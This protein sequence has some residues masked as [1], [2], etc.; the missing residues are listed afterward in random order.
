ML[1]AP[2][3]ETTVQQ[4]VPQQP[5]E[6]TLEHVVL[7]EDRQNPGKPTLGTEKSVR[8]KEQQGEAVLY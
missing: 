6:T 7:S 1:Q 3:R 8:R 5:M 2:S 4:V